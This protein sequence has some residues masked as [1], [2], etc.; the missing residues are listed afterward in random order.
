MTQVSRRH[1]LRMASMMGVA[2]FARPLQASA[3]WITGKPSFIDYPFKLGVASGDPL[4]TGFVIWTRLVP[5]LLDDRGAGPDPILVHYEVAADEKFRKPVKKGNVIAYPENGHSVHADIQGLEPG[6]PYWYRFMAGGEESDVG[7]ALTAPAYMSPVDQYKFA[8]AS[9]Q[10]F[11]DGYFKAY[12]DIIDQDAQLIVHLGDYIYEESYSPTFRRNPVKI[13]RTLPDYRALYATYKMDPDLQAAHRH[14]SWLCTWDDHEVA[15]DYAAQ[16]DEDFE[17]VETFLK[18]R[19][20]A[21][22]AYFEHMPLRRA[23]K[24]V[25]PDATIYQRVFFGD[26]LE[27]NMLDTR[28]YRTDQPC[29]LPHDGGWRIIKDTCEERFDPDRTILGKDQEKWLLSGLGRAG[30]KWN[31]MAQGMLFSKHDKLPGEEVGYGSEYWDG[32]VASRNNVLGTIEKR[33]IKNTVIIGGDVHASYVCDVKQDFEKPESKTLASEFVA[34]SISSNNF[35][36]AQT[37]KTLPENPHIKLYEGRHRGYT[38]CTLDKQTWKTDLRIVDD[39]REKALNKASTFKSYVIED[40][41]AGPQ[42]A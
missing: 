38:L 19:A 41:V 32:Y 29:Q 3:P 14:T 4:P 6:R 36:H 27:I 28:Q 39:V 34:T 24:P 7:R 30:A 37:M 33:N 23:A 42:E 20:D 40:G 16:Y 31:V 25:G 5:I 22:K 10:N 21:Y 13:A 11:E 9:C 35:Y 12:R 2:A 17:P 18:R 15:N 8:F 26:M 1:L